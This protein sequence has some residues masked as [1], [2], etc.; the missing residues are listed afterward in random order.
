[1]EKTRY[2]GVYR[3]KNGRLVIR[4]AFRVGKAFK[5]KQKTLPVGTSLSAAVVMLEELKETVRTEAT[6][7]HLP[8]AMLRVDRSETIE[9]YAYRWL[10]IKKQRLAPSSYHHHES[11]IYTRILP[12]IGH[13]RC[14]DARRG[15]VGRTRG[16]QPAIEL[17]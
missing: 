16:L 6:L 15:R 12:R 1:M 14:Q 8:Q 7:G 17:P 5:D 10:E 2:P 11:T 13:V 4:A 9:D 3:K